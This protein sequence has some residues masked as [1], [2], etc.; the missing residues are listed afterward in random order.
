MSQF[1][2]VDLITRAAK[3]MRERA[4]AASPGPWVARDDKRG[5]SIRHSGPSASATDKPEAQNLGR[6]V[7]CG[8]GAY[9]LGLPSP[10][11]TAHIVSWHPAVALAVSDWLDIG[12]NPYA[13]IDLTPMLAVARAYLGQLDT[14]SYSSEGEEA[15]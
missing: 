8:V 2:H 7:V 14:G 4:L 9:D 13:C 3:L 12:A 15:R 1:P 5:G 11:D 6:Y 10:A